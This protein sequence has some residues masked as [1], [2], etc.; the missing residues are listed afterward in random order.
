MVSLLLT[1]PGDRE[2]AE[3]QKHGDDGGLGRGEHAGEITRGKSG[4][5]TWLK[6]RA[7]MLLA[8]VLY[9]PTRTNAVVRCWVCL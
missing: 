7:M 9:V 2:G 4:S 5:Y 8:I 3:D 6:R 1:E